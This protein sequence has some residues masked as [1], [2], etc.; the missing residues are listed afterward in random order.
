LK[1]FTEGLAA[2]R[3][4]MPVVK[5]IELLCGLAFLSGLFVPLATVVIFPIALNILFVHLLLAPEGLPIAMFLML[6]NL[7]LA[8]ACR[9]HYRPL[10]SMRIDRLKS[11]EQSEFSVEESPPRRK[12]EAT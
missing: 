6:G 9:N 2:S 12:T 10:F 8:Y 5:V 1:T 4:V 7:F 11:A 3:Y